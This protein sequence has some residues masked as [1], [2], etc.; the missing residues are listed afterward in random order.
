[1][2]KQ[3]KDSPFQDTGTPHSPKKQL[4]FPAPSHNSKQQN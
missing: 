1:M 2:N 4:L 3:Q